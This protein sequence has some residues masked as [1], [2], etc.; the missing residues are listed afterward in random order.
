[1][2]GSTC[3]FSAVATMIAADF[4]TGEQLLEVGGHKVGRGV[5]AEADCGLLVDVAQ[6]EPADPGVLAGEYGPDPADGATTDDRKPD[7]HDPSASCMM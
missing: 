7:R 3:I 1:M 4:G 6:T 5:V 2:I